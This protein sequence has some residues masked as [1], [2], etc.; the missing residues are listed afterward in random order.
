MT[1]NQ[2]IERCNQLETELER[3]RG[4]SA[5]WEQ[6]WLDLN[7]EVKELRDIKEAFFKVLKYCK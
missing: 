4:R 1:K 7:Q 2:L 3:C 6:E 5:Y